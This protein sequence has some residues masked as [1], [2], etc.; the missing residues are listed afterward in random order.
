MIIYIVVTENFYGEDIRFFYD[1]FDAEKYVNL[2]NIDSK[3]LIFEINDTSKIFIVVSE[4]YYGGNNIK[5]FSCQNQAKNYKNYL[6]NKY[7]INYY[8][9]NII[10][11]NR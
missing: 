9:K 5:C 6:K 10:I 2:L 8:I 1:Y 11:N 7:N 3:I 4:E